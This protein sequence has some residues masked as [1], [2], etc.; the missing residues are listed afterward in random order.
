MKDKEKGDDI[1]HRLV[2]ADIVHAVAQLILHHTRY[3][4]LSLSNINQ[5]L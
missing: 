3:F 4:N 1:Q 5:L 2:G